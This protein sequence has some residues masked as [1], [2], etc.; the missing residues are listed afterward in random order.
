MFKFL[1]EREIQE[2]Q[3]VLEGLFEYAHL[4]DLRDSLEQ[5]KQWLIHKNFPYCDDARELENTLYFF[6][7]LQGLIEAS[8]IIKNQS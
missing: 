1:T 2:P 4:A 5:N 8:Y 7:K 6:E 3:I